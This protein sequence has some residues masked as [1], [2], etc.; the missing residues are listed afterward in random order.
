MPAD[1]GAWF[2]GSGDGRTAPSLQAVP[3]RPSTS[4]MTASD[5]RVLEISNDLSLEREVVTIL[6]PCCQGHG[7]QQDNETQPSEEW[8]DDSAHG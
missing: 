6:A 7:G 8:R 5:H 1:T 4:A 3:T 2:L